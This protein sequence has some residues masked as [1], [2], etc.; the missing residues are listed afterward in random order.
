MST[1]RISRRAA[2]AIVSGGAAFAIITRT[3]APKFHAR[4]LDG[5][6]YTNQTLL[7]RP[8]LIQFWTTWCPVCRR[9]QDTVETLVEEYGKKRLV[10][11]AV[12]V[13]ESRKKVT[14]Y[15]RSSPRSC[16]IV[17][18]EDTNLPAL[19]AA[20]VYPFYVVIDAEGMIVGEQRGA[21]EGP[22]RGLLR[23][24]GLG[25]DEPPVRE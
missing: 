13:G 7:G 9:D 11:L 8:A 21:G 17:L 3:A 25:E 6:K 23:K 1:H 18:N 20:R 12:D 10:V 14:E 19:F 5:E 2:L 24:A 4:T 22:L 16:K 15:L